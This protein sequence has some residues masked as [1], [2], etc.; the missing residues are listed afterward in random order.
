MV[1]TSL[2]SRQRDRQSHILGLA[3]LSESL[4]ATIHAPSGS[5]PPVWCAHQSRQT[6]K[7][8]EVWCQQTFVTRTTPARGK[9]VCRL[10]LSEVPNR[11]DGPQSVFEQ[12]QCRTATVPQPMNETVWALSLGLHAKDARR[13]TPSGQFR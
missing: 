12:C 10:V 8:Q 5:L 13:L 6:P 1:Q 4:F 9:E 2:T 11:P 7:L 3:T